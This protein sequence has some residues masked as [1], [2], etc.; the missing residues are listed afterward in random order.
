MGKVLS[1]MFIGKYGNMNFRI[2]IACLHP[3]HCWFDSG[4]TSGPVIEN[5][6]DVINPFASN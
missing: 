3:S 2:K 5:H 1:M 6:D 4:P